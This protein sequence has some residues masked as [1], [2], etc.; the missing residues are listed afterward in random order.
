MLNLSLT[1][2][3]P[4]PAFNLPPP[5]MLYLLFIT[6]LAFVV[7]YSSFLFRD[8]HA[9]TRASLSFSFS[10]RLMRSL[11]LVLNPSLTVYSPYPAF[12][13]PPLDLLYTCTSS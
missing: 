5:D 3:S 9:H 12:N 8:S 13:L 4:Y 2:Y 11:R 10:P 6:T 1:V 7:L